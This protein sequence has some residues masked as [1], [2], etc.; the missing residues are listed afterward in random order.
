M[1]FLF[2]GE[3][4]SSSGLW[5]CGNR[6]AISK[7]R[8]E[9]WKTIHRSSN[10][11]LLPREIHAFHPTRHFHSPLMYSQRFFR[12]T[13]R[14]QG[15]SAAGAPALLLWCWFRPQL[16]RR[17]GDH[18]V[19]DL[20]PVKPHLQALIAP[21][22]DRHPCPRPHALVAFRLQLQTTILE[23]HHPVVAHHA[24]VLATEHPSQLGAAGERLVKVRCRRRLTGEALVVLGQVLLVEITVRRLVLDD[25]AQPHLLDQAVLVRAVM[26]LHSALGAARKPP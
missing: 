9:G 1:C 16:W 12:N 18:V 3:I 2:V 6:V 26:A 17:R 22:L 7:G 11:V 20:V 23:T 19:L 10:P 24:F 15:W 21:L 14:R 8:W 5:N 25:P 4:S 13:A